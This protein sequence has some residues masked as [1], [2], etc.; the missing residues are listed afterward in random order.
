MS[1]TGHSVSPPPASGQRAATLVVLA[2]LMAMSAAAWF[3]LDQLERQHRESVGESLETIVEVSRGTLRTR[4]Q[5]EGAHARHIARSAVVTNA[6]WELL[7]GERSH[8]RLAAHTSTWRLRQAL[9]TGLASMHP[10]GY[11]VVASDNTIIASTLDEQ[12]GQAAPVS[13][14]YPQLLRRAFGG[15]IVVLP[16]AARLRG[17]T[18]PTHHHVASIAVPIADERQLVIAVLVL[19]FDLERVLIQSLH[20]GRQGASGETYAFDVNARMISESRFFD[21]LRQAGVL[22]HQELATGS[23]FVTDPGTDVLR[24]DSPPLPHE[25]R[26]LTTMAASATAGNTS[27]DVGGYRDYRGRR[28]LGAWIWDA[29][30]NLGLTSEI[31]EAEALLTYEEN[32]NLVLMLLAVV[33]VLCAGLIYWVRRQGTLQAEHLRRARDEWQRLARARALDLQAILDATPSAV[34]ISRQD[35]VRYAN[36]KFVETFGMNVGDDAYS[37]YVDPRIKRLIFTQLATGKKLD[38]IQVQAKSTDGK[39]LD[40]MALFRHIDYEGEPATMAFLFDVT[41]LK[42]TEQALRD[43]K[44]AAEAATRAKSSFLANMSHEIRTPMNAILGYA[45]LLLRSDGLSNHQ[46]DQL[47]VIRRSGNHLLVVIDDI[48]EMSRLEAGRGTL[49]ER[50]F[51]LRATLREVEDMFREITRNKGLQ[52]TFHVSPELPNTIAADSSKVRQVL[53]N[54]LSNAAK[55]TDQG[56]IDVYAEA[57]K[58]DED[59]MVLLIRVRDTGCGVSRESAEHI[60]DAFDQTERG[61]REGGTGLGLAISR[62]FARLM[63]GDLTLEDTEGDG[64]TFTFSFEC[65]VAALDRSGQDETLPEVLGLAADQVPPR[66]LIVDDV[67]TNR[68]LLQELLQK[69]GFSTRTAISG[70]EALEAHAQWFPTLVLMDLR[71]PGMGGLEAIRQLRARGS[72]AAIIAITA[73]VLDQERAESLEAGANEFLRKPYRESELLMMLRDILGVRYRAAQAPEPQV[74]ERVT[75]AECLAAI[76]PSLPSELVDELKEAAVQ[77]R[78]QQITRLA[79]RVAAHSSEAAIEVRDLAG[80][81][82]YEVLLQ[83]LSS[84]AGR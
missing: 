42:R 47:D 25:S 2:T 39:L 30:L 11:Q 19:S 23:L 72:T 48:L 80:S 62:Q 54:L 49:N 5:S 55:F 73:S 43:A 34:A 74:R 17:A 64:S 41:R 68:E 32:R 79:E 60:F 35:V 16:H 36:P 26:K 56:G 3:G 65:R 31:D 70:E 9:T 53:V 13:E 40:L 33:A 59:P 46:R 8:Q 38:D 1:Q 29:E 12:L 78:A 10:Q 18:P 67:P 57:R 75:A 45:Q 66:V 6:A 50:A 4:L 44:D 52:L 21:D 61:A 51:D 37:A 14:T 63:N 76:V 82:R 77:A 22:S 81:F 27:M 7:R 28:V 58:Q 71:M 69:V 24:G 20:L 84:D 83:A 15:E